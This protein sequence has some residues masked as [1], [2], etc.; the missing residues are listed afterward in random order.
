MGRKMADVKRRYDASGRREQAA[1]RRHRVLRAA[2]TLFLE[3]GY[4]ATTIAQTAQQAGVSVETVYKAFRNK[5]ELVRAVVEQALEGSGPT[6]AESRSDLLHDQFDDP[7]DVVRGWG[8]LAAEVSPRVAPLLLLVAAG[9]A[10]DPELER[11]RDELDR[12]RRLRMRHNAR[13]LAHRGHL[14]DGL[15]LTQA[16]DILWTYSAPELYDLLV[17]RRGWTARR[18]GQFVADGIASQCLRSTGPTT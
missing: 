16:S 4:A 5:P 18:F 10:H 2:R 9:A 14:R 1:V 6:T 7:A 17:L 15:T 8:A 11:L 12:A 3:Q 13:Q